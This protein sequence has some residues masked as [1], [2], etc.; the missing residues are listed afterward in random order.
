VFDLMARE[1]RR[2]TFRIEHP[3]HSR[4]LF[5]FMGHNNRMLWTERGIEWMTE[6]VLKL[7]PVNET[8]TYRL[9]GSFQMVDKLADDLK[10]KV[11]AAL[12][13]L[14]ARLDAAQYP[15]VTGRIRAFLGRS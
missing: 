3:N 8:T 15:S 4:S 13:T 1:E 5:L 6:T 12:E 9:L 7:A 10:P 11:R 14:L 2:P